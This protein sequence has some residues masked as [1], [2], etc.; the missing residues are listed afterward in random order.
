[1]PET[2]LAWVTPPPGKGALDT[3][4][5]RRPRPFRTLSRAPRST[6]GPGRGGR[7]TTLTGGGCVPSLEPSA[8]WADRLPENECRAEVRNG[9][10]KPDRPGSKGGWRSHEP[11]E[12]D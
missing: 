12:P 9:L 10:G 6:W 4:R 2:A 11:W 8:A 3:R 1:V 5:S 7:P